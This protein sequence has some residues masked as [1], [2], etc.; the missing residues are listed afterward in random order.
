M[1]LIALKYPNK[2]KR[3]GYWKRY[4][5]AK[6]KNF[7]KIWNFLDK[8]ID[9][10]GIPFVKEKR[11]R[12]P[13]LT[14][15]IITK[16]C[17]FIGYFDLTLDEMDGLLDLLENKTLD[18]SNIDRWF[19]KFDDEYALKATQLLHQKIEE[20]FRKGEY[21]VDSTKYTTNQY[22]EM[23]HKGKMIIELLTMKLHIFIVYFFSVGIL[24]IANFSVTHGDAHDAPVY[25]DEL[26]E[27]ISLKKNRRSHKDKAYDDE[28]TFEKEFEKGLIPNTVP[29]EN[30]KKGFWRKKAR[31]VYNNELRKKMRG[32][33][34]GVFG[35]MQTETDN[36]VRYKLDKTRKT[37]IALRALAHEI[38]TYLRALEQKI[39]FLFVNF[40]TTP[41]ED[42]QSRGG[43]L[44]GIQNI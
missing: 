14:L 4:F 6:I 2:K 17:I 8:I 1:E 37:Y 40:A 32:L 41:H 26:L 43:V 30:S 12:H 22:H 18:R 33:V 10:L 13:K 25:R 42:T 31:R 23:I 21:I 35:G 29:K 5:R 7:R 9:E 24:S 3:K 38:R 19:I 20:M 27:D 36:K 34:E 15:H 16:M 39:I 28:D 44:E 11:G